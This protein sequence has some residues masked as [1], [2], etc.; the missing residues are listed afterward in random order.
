M[1]KGIEKDYVTPLSGD[2]IN[3]GKM[4]QLHVVASKVGKWQFIFTADAAYFTTFA[5]SPEFAYI[6]PD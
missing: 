6:T 5:R 3:G 1:A 2:P 4:Q